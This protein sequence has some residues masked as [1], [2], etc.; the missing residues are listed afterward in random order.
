MR[1]PIAR[2][3][4]FMLLCCPVLVFSQQP[5]SLLEQA[6][7]EHVIEYAIKH[8]PLIQQ[9]LIDEGITAS[10]IKSKLADWYPQVNFNY[11]LQH[12]FKLQTTVFG[13]NTIQLGTKN[14][15]F[16]QFAATQHIFNRDVLLA[17]RTASEVRNLARQNTSNNKIDLSVSVTKAFYDALSSMQQLKVAEE[18]ITRL[19]RSLKDATNQY[20]A[21]IT[22]KIDYK[23][24]TIALN[25][26]IAA[27]KTNEA[28]LNAKLEYL[29][30]LIGYPQG[31]H[32]PIVYDSLQMEKEVGFDTLQRAE[33]SNRI[34]YRLLMTQKK[35]QEANLRYYKWGYLPD[36]SANGA[37]NF[38]YLNN[39]FGKLYSAGYPNAFAALT[40]SFPIFQGG[41]RKANI[42]QADWQLKR[43][44]WDVIKLKNAVNTEYARALASYKSNLASYNALKENMQ[45]AKEVYDVI[46]LQYQS[47]LKTYL[48]V[49][50]AETDLRTARINYYTSLYQALSSKV[51]VQHA[52]GQI[53]Y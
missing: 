24:A 36:V 51:D 38:N 2:I 42:E 12:N 5:D 6:T 22:D 9:S 43:I 45:L 34:E 11:N 49:I 32:L 4:G 53:N 18:A 7:L 28:I 23:R 52:L 40:L 14:T 41:K 25:N 29:K 8:Q 37:Y 3:P 30:G 15:S 26:A 27:Q 20:H 44:N 47:G 50:T 10:T 33:Y 35:L 31:N 46:R 19:E 21:G 17:S 48:E 13:G 1:I 39:D 16:L